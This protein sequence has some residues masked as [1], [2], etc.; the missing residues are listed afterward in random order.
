MTDS[1]SCKPCNQKRHDGCTNRGCLCDQHD[2]PHPHPSLSRP[3]HWGQPQHAPCQSCGNPVPVWAMGCE[4]CGT[5]L[6]G[7]NNQG[8]A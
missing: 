1:A 6:T 8:A 5:Y 2:H 3:T 4:Q 7:R